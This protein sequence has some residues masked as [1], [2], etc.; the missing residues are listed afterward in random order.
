M[1]PEDI[2]IEYRL[3]KDGITLHCLNASSRQQIAEVIL[4]R[5][6]AIAM[7]D[8]LAKLVPLVPDDAKKQ[9]AA[10]QI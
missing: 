1:K 5:A 3:R 6:G 4:N 10:P 7:R 8:T 9:E 2:E